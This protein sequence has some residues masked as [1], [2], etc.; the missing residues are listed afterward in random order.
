M[1]YLISLENLSYSIQGKRIVDN[2]NF[3][4]EKNKIFIISGHNGAGKTTLLRLMAGI[5]IPTSGKINY[6]FT[7]KKIKH[8][9]GPLSGF[10]FQ[11]PIFLNRTVYENLKHTLYSVYEDITEKEVIELISQILIK[12]KINHLSNKLLIYYIK[13]I[14]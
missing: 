10:I 14:T 2:V 8:I 5:I 12:F 11:K 4:I 13:L 6:N 3:G 7:N 1:N 9:K